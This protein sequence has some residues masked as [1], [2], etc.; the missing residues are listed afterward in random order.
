M[1]IDVYLNWDGMTEEDKE[2]QFTGF[3]VHA[4]KIGYLREA[5]HGEPYATFILFSEDWDKQPEGGFTIANS[6]LKERLA[7]TVK[8]AMERER[9]LYRN[10]EP[11][12]FQSFIDFVEL[13][14]RLEKEGKN[15]RIVISA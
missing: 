11:K 12:T 10:R 5:Y 4:G 3:S 8:V 6:V 9:K 15:P 14:G 1:G 13:H 7:K 2:K